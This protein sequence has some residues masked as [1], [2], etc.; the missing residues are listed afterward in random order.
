MR[1]MEPVELR[2]EIVA[3]EPLTA[4]HAEGILAAADS[5]EVFAWLPYPRPG[6]LRAAGGW[7]AAALG[8][9]DTNCRLPFAVR[10]REG[11]SVIGST[12]YWDF[13]GDMGAVES[14]APCW[15]SPHVGGRCPGSG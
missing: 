8:D 14:S 5:D 11:D 4:E 12:S 13:D 9:R 15:L 7:I 6:D 10:R 2:G 1:P 3:A